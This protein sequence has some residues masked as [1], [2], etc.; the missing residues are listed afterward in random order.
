LGTLT[1]YIRELRIKHWVKNL[2]LFAAP[3]FGGVLFKDS[4]LYLALPAFVSFSLCA[5]AVYIINDIVDIKTD[6]LHP[7]KTKARN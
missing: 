3:F 5:S 6:L 4:T 7:K 1:D 2:F